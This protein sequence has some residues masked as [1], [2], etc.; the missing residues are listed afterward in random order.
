M[1]TTL[2]K[3]IYGIGQ[4]LKPTLLK[5]I[6]ALKSG[7]E[8]IQISTYDGL[9]NSIREDQQGI[10]F[11]LSER[12][13]NIIDENEYFSRDIKIED[14]RE[15]FWWI[16]SELRHQEVSL[17]IKPLYKPL[18][19]R[20]EKIGIIIFIS[21]KSL[22]VELND[23]MNK[24]YMIISE[25][26]YDLFE[27]YEKNNI[28]RVFINSMIRM[29]RQDHPEIYAHSLRTADLSTLI[30][31]AM[32]L[33]GE[34]V[35]CLRNAAIIHD[36]GGIFIPKKFLKKS[37]NL[38][39]IEKDFYFS[40]TD[41]LFD[42]FQ[43]NPYMKDILEIAYK[44]HEKTNKTGKYG[45]GPK[46][47]NVLDNILIICNEFDNMYHEE[48]ELK[49]VKQV[50]DKMQTMADN[51][52]IDKNVFENSKEIILSFYGGYLN[53]S[54]VASIGISKNIHVQDPVNK[55]EMHKANV[56]NSLGNLII[57][58]FEKDPNFSLGR[59]LIF[60]CDVGGLIEKFDAKIISET[61][62]DYTMLVK[63]KKNKKGKTLKV[64]WNKEANL[65]KIPHDLDA[66]EEIK[67]NFKKYFE[68]NIIVRTLGGSEL[69]F[70]CE[71]TYSIGD[72]RIIYFEYKG[73]KIIIPGIIK[74]RF[75]QDKKNVYDF[76]YLE[77]KD[78]DLSKV[79]RTIFKKQVEMKLK[80]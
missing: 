37:R 40:H 14:Y 12:I 63:A 11:M 49:T 45:L 6:V 58:K 1:E 4:E 80:V 17:Y 31:K 65:Y 66:L 52:L 22:T 19:N 43:N 38:L 35:E 16:L 74:S 56:I 32:Q 33:K 73:E 39:E 61:K 79:Y 36:F 29:L 46:D 75:K 54:P 3:L 30:A 8:Y 69:I 47:L 51:N 59:N 72:K 7:D 50:I 76:E 48:N 77:M 15:Q 64:Y 24:E 25:A 53:L 13:N 60:M 55:N 9:T 21:M 34:D 70:D 67:T 5:G 28:I 27:K 2:D 26:T 78:K 41:K 44:H 42:L 57:I 10:T 23:I 68:T 20:K 62:S 71:E 18:I